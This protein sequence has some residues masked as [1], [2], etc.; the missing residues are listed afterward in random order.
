MFCIEK[1]EFKFLFGKISANLCSVVTLK[2]VKMQ[3]FSKKFKI[4]HFNFL[5]TFFGNYLTFAPKFISI[6]G[7]QLGLGLG[8]SPE[9]IIEK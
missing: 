2:V 6:I 1:F 7:L 5:H 4:F 9:E 3:I 8:F